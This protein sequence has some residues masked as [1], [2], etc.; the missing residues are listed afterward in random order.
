MVSRLLNQMLH[1]G[2]IRSIFFFFLLKLRMHFMKKVRLSISRG[3]FCVSSVSCIHGITIHILTKMQK[4]FFFIIVVV[5]VG[6]C[7]CVFKVYDKKH[8]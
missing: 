1:G 3:I 5:F 8:R 6:F 7:V 2:K 4:N